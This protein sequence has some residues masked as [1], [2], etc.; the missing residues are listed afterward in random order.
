MIVD[1]LHIM[2]ITVQPSKYDPPLIVH[3][4]RIKISQVSAQLLQSIRRGNAQIL[5]SSGN[6]HS[7]ELPLGPIREAMECTNN[8]VLEKSPC[9]TVAE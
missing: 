6:M 4:D 5:Q 1:D 8:L 2:S 3:T 7:D 9:P